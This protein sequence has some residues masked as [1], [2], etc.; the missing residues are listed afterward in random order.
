MQGIKDALEVVGDDTMQDLFE[1]VRMRYELADP[2]K[3]FLEWV[4]A[5]R[6]ASDVG[7]AIYGYA[8]SKE[9]INAKGDTT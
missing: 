4:E 6:T 7:L 3:D 8:K 5:L 1:F 9:R 2:N